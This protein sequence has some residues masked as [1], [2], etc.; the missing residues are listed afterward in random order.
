M[1]DS[2]KV[3]S[4]FGRGHCDNVLNLGQN[5]VQQ[6]AHVHRIPRHL[7]WISEENINCTR[8]GF[9]SDCCTTVKWKTRHTD[10]QTDRL[11]D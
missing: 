11:T 6:Q 2:E 3:Q 5:D 7:D 10:R 8:N 4:C 9:E 1:A